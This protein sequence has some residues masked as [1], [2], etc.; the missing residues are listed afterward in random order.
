M[1]AIKI[2]DLVKAVKGT[3][4]AG[5]EDDRVT[6]VSTDSRSVKEGGLF[7]PIIGE[8]VD[9]HDFIAGALTLGGIATFTSRK[10][11]KIEF[12]PGKAYI[13]VEDT[14]TALQDF[15]AYYRRLFSIPLI[16]ITGSVGKTTTKE[17]VAAALATRYKVL[18][19]I[20]NMN[21]QVGLPLMMFEIDKTT[22]IAV[23]E[24]GMSEEGEMS[25]LAKV[26]RPEAVIM[27]NIGV[28]H[29]GQLGSQENIRKEK[30][31]IINGFLET[32]GG[33]LYLNGEDCLLKEIGQK[34]DL[35]VTEE[36]REA[37]KQTKFIYYGIPLEDADLE[38]AD[39]EKAI[40]NMK[41]DLKGTK[42]ISEAGKTN[43]LFEGDGKAEEITLSVLGLHNVG[44]ALAALGVAS[45]YGIPLSVAK[46]G[47][48]NY[49]PISGRGQII[50]KDGIILIDDTYNA[51]PD[52]MKSGI[53]VLLHTEGRTRRIAVLADV[54][55][56]GE[57]SSDYHYEVG[58]YIGKI[59][60]NQAAVDMLITV[61]NDSRFI[62]E[63]VLS[64]D[65]TIKVMHFKTNEEA[66]AFLKQELKSGDG[67]LVKG[68][69]GM[70]T[71]EIIKGMI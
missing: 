23:I 38:D 28:S 48:R 2:A 10:G 6:S 13:Q 30:L 47:L 11:E 15:A 49:E 40:C 58:E 4:L 68:S 3:L 34:D 61:G 39:S 62:G 16:G 29:I 32:Q 46:E 65:T 33:I 27:T 37:L 12:I 57:N 36:T 22:E 52:S 64:C 63:G 56:L 41:F 69:R 44:N 25:R 31:N 7:V 55:E 18:K 66:A 43:F 17:M 45:Q 21:S 53:Q 24:M 20:G 51:S 70:H 59:K 9:A 54:L 71:E 60:N 67:I 8:R 5:E 42:I 19:T 50:E 35:D 1:E 26:A 14:L